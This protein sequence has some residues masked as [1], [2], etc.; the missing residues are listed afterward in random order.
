[1]YDLKKKP[2]LGFLL[3]G[4]LHTLPGTGVGAG[5]NHTVL[6]LALFAITSKSKS[7]FCA[8]HKSTTTDVPCC[9]K[10]CLWIPPLQKGSWDADGL[11]SGVCFF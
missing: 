3:L 1:M 9:C 4:H 11:G 8:F 7:S 5:E 2:Y 6:F 10:V